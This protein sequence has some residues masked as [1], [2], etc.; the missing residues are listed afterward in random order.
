VLA[1]TEITASVPFTATVLKFDAQGVI[2]GRAKLSLNMV[3][4]RGEATFV[5]DAQ[6]TAQ[7]HV[8]GVR[9]PVVA[10]GPVSGPFTTRTWVRFDGRKFSLVRTT[11]WAQV[12]GDLEGV[13]G[14]HGHPLGRAAGHFVRPLGQHLVPRAEAEATP[15]SEEILTTLV[16]ELAA[17]I[18]ARL[19]RIT[20]VDPEGKWLFPRSGNWVWQ[21]SGDPPF[22]QLTQ[23][24]R[25]RVVQLSTDPQLLAL[26]QEVVSRLNRDTRVERLL[27]QFFPET[28]DWRILMSSDSQFLQA[29]YG[30]GR[31]TVPILPEHPQRRQDVRLEIWLPST[32]EEAQT[33]EKL[34]RLPLSKKLTQEYLAAILPELAGLSTVV[35]NVSVDAVGSWVVM[36]IGAPKAE[37]GP[38]QKS[39]P[40]SGKQ[41]DT[42]GR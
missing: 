10:Y 4:A 5:V 9:G 35:D 40:S 18:V 32:S 38:A 3:T 11:P 17:E 26:A 30:P 39:A 7:S 19:N 22:L 28:G 29:A 42:A 6:G 27:N 14:S 37:T 34:S 13:E 20:R 23:E 24:A 15:I 16:N 12:H 25:N 33:L 8:R 36:S 41:S 1:R 21:L 31:S 2:Q